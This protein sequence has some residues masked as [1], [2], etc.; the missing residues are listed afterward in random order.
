MF[1]KI[2]FSKNKLGHIRPFRGV[3]ELTPLESCCGSNQIISQNKL[4][5][6]HFLKWC[7]HSLE[8]SSRDNTVTSSYHFVL[9][10]NDKNSN[11]NTPMVSFL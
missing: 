11:L 7:D 9:L 1:L 10:I 6:L 3:T 8:S 2:Y 4:S 5:F